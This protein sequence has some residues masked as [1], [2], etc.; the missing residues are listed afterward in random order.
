MAV[1]SANGI[2]IAYDERGK[3]DNPAI[4]LIMGLGTQMIAWPEEFCDGLAARGFRVVRFD[5]RDIGLSTKLEG[6]RPV[7]LTTLFL[8]AF[9]GL[10]VRSP[11]TLNDMARDAVGLMDRLGIDRAHVVGASMGGMIGQIAAA[12]HPSRVRSLVSIMSTSGA[13]GL[14]SA[15]SEAMAALRKPRPDARDREAA[16]QHGM[17]VYRAIG[18]PGFATPEAE[19]RQKVERAFDRSYYPAG[20]GRQLAAIVANGSR[21]ELLKRITAPTLVIHGADDPLV[22]LAAGKD[23][24]ARIRGAQLEVIPG[25]GHDLPTALVPHIVQSIAAHCEAADG[26]PVQGAAAAHG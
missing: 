13:R 6:G 8:R 12:E 11:Y 18:S 25:M 15:K 22:P 16:I 2:E 19:L 5:N 3:P 10:P 9:I 20:V 7:N 26:R 1:V 23:T 4:V 14:P 24:A 21:V 17:Y